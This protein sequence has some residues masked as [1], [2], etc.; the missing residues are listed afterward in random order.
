MKISGPLLGFGSPLLDL[1]VHVPEEVVAALPGGKGGM[2]SVDAAWHRQVTAS[3][4]VRPVTAPGGSAGN[5]VFALA[6]LG[7]ACSMLG[8]LGADEGGDFYRKRLRELGGGDDCFFSSDSAATGR[9]L[10]LITPDGERTMRTDLGASVL[11]TADEV[12]QVDF[13][14]FGIVLIEGYM[15]FNSP[16]FDAVCR[17]AEEAGCVIAM[18]MSSY[19]VVN[20]FRDRIEDAL[21]RYVDVI[22]AN[23]DEAR[24]FLPEASDDRS[25]LEILAGRCRTAVIKQGADGALIAGPDGERISVPAMKVAKVCDTTA[26]GDLWQAGFLAGLLRGWDMARAGALGAALSGE[27]VQVTG[28][29]LPEDAWARIESRWPR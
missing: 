2:E 1:L 12:E 27:V 3:L 28:S 5:T 24:T 20:I 6:R 14:R 7:E 16:A 11:L 10:S 19:E 17:C 26:A 15:L 25:R 23:Q 9:C 8:K 13:R 29:V 22:F 4:P 18:D 21:D